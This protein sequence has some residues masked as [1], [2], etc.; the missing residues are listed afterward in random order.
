MTQSCRTLPVFLHCCLVCF[1]W[2]LISFVQFYCMFSFPWSSGAQYWHFSLWYIAIWYEK[3]SLQ[4][5]S[6]SRG[7][8]GM[9]SLKTF[10]YIL[11]LHVSVWC[12]MR[13][14]L[15][16]YIYEERCAFLN[17]TVKWDRVCVWRRVRWVS[18]IAA[19]PWSNDDSPS[20]S[21]RER[22]P[23]S[24]DVC[25]G[26]RPR[27]FQS[28]PRAGHGLWSPRT[29]MEEMRPVRQSRVDEGILPHRAALSRFESSW[30][31]ATHVCV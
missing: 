11:K 18:N 7:V 26:G 15:R 30:Q 29:A 2:W 12:A 16:G 20:R 28:W 9:L 8:Q 6:P 19:D 25:P 22:G 23:K 4:E 24:S 3:N 13:A 17:K 14:K 1:W 21:C 27:A 5:F 10:Q 31:T